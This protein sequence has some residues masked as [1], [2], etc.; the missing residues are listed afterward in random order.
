[1]ADTSTD[2]PTSGK[3]AVQQV[4]GSPEDHGAPTSKGPGARPQCFKTTMQELMYTFVVTMAS[5][6]TSLIIGAI[7]VMSTFIAKDLHMTDAEI[8]WIPASS[9]L[10]SGAFLLGF[11]QACDLFG[12]KTLLLASLSSLTIFC[13][14]TGF[15]STGVGLDA[16]NGVLGL[17]SASAIPAALGILGAA[18]DKPSK[19]KNYAFAC[20]SAGNPLGFVF[21]CILGGV[22]TQLASWRATFWSLAVVFALTTIIA[23][24]ATPVDDSEKMPW[25]LST[26]KRFDF[27]GTLLTI[28]GV[29]LLSAALTEG[30]EAPSG[31]KTPYIIVLLVLG[32]ALLVAFVFWERFYSHPL[33]PLQIWNDRNFALLNIILLLGFLAFPIALFWLALFLQRVWHLSP[34]SV[35]VHLLP[36]AVSGILVNIVAGLVLHK[37]SNKILMGLGAVAYTI[38]FLLLALNKSTSSYWAFYFPGLALMV[39]GA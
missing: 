38:A 34:L 24:F 11:G 4:L 1:M 6:T 39:V 19:R 27:I 32:V 18:Y 23:G 30:A 16:L 8:A 2:V 26:L 15:A 3:N 36:A 9:S 5:A 13:V 20:F 25:R 10:T 28:S 35:A 22:A 12:R 33:M 21:G 7:I 31:W 37:V 29:A 14:A 17:A